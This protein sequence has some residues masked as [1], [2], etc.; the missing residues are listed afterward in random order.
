MSWLGQI[1]QDGHWQTVGFYTLVAFVPYQYEHRADAQ[2]MLISV[3]PKSRPAHRRT[4]DPN[5]PPEGE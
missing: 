1:R 2:Q 4:I 5:R 3:F